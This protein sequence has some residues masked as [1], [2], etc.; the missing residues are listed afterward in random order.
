MVRDVAWVRRLKVRDN[1]PI[2]VVGARNDLVTLR[3]VTVA[4]GQ[5]LA[6]SLHVLFL[7]TSAKNNAN[8]ED[9]F[10]NLVREMRLTTQR[11]SSKCVIF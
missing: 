4:E 3:Q 8:V 11:P 9:A 5:E 10:R 7:E 6:S 1:V 2:I